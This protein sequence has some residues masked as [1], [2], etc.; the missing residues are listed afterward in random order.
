MALSV[1]N[2]KKV[3]YIGLNSSPIRSTVTS[4]Y[5][6]TRRKTFPPANGGFW[7]EKSDPLGKSCDECEHKYEM[8]HVGPIVR[9]D[10]GSSRRA[11]REDRS[12]HDDLFLLLIKINRNRKEQ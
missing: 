11:R 7:E 4:F 1:L 8:S 6:L 12:K 2:K 9:H 10:D 5:L 3:R